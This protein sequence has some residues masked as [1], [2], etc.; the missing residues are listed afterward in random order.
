MSI[1]MNPYQGIN[2][3]AAQQL[4][5]LEEMDWVGKTTPL[6]DLMLVV[7]ECG[8]AANEVRGDIP[9]KNFETELADIVLRVMGIA[10]KNNIHLGYAIK[11]KMEYNLKKGKKSGRVK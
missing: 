5:W 10:A 11:N 4:A 6:E 9:T 1:C 3:L 7:S 2:I 8:E